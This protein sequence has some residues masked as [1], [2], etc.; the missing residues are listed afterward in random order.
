VR[1]AL[2]RGVFK[3][4]IALFTFCLFTQGLAG[5]ADAAQS[6]GMP[7][8]QHDGLVWADVL[9]GGRTL[10]FVVDTGAMSSCINL[11]AAKRLGL[12]LGSRLNVSGVGGRTV[13]YEC[14]GFHATAGGMRLP[15]DVVALDLSG[16]ARGCSEPIDGLIGADFFRGKVVR[17]DYAREKLSEVPEPAG[18]IALR[19]A[20]GVMCVPVAING[21]EARWARLDTGCTNALDWCEEAGGSAKVHGKSVALTSWMA[22][23]GGAPR[24]DVTVGNAHLRGIPVRMHGR[25]IFPGEAGLLGNGVLSRYCVTIDGIGNRLLLE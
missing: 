20:N 14:T 19:F 21:G 1:I 3:T 16:P 7:I 22:W 11:A 13:G 6:Q 17:I 8:S 4:A 25:E 9:S 23:M 5:A 18:G 10:H 12:K 24:A 15:Q 2:A